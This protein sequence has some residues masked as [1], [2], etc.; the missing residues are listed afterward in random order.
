MKHIGIDGQLFDLLCSYLT[1]REM[2]V[3]IQGSNSKWRKIT[4]GV[5]QG[6][7]LGPLLFLIYVN[8]IIENL[9]SEIY[10]Y[11]DDAVLMLNFRRDNTNACFDQLN[12]DLERLSTWAERW[13]MLFNSTKTKY[14]IVSNKHQQQY[15]ELK[16]DGECLERVSNYPQLGLHL[17]ENMCWAEHI[18]HLIT[19]ASK[20]IGLIWKLSGNIPRHAVENIYT[21]HI[22]P[23]L[24]YGSL[25]YS[26]CTK[27]QSSRL[28]ALQRRAAIACTRAYNKTS[29]ENLL[30]ELGW[31]TLE[32][33]RN[34]AALVQF[35]KMS[36]DQTP[37]YLQENYSHQDMATTEDTP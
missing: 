4:A 16:L 12:R 33:R 24:E 26:N 34:Y 3:V 9:E 18:D 11:A 22:R 37:Q 35:Y 25:L 36:H 23:Q 5:P 15:P 29:S 7:I 8:D 32:S 30:N 21:A 27:E 14:M 1:N 6:S 10:L 13:L 20:K 2:R 19:K 31:P 17:N 28:E